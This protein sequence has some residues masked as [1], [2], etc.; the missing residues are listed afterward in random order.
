MQNVDRAFELQYMGAV[1]MNKALWP[2]TFGSFLKF[3][4]DPVFSETDIEKAK[5][6]AIDNVYARGPAPA[7]RIGAVPYGVL[8]VA[9][10]ARWQPR[11][12]EHDEADA[13]AVEAALLGPL[14][15]MASIWKSAASGVGRVKP[16]SQTPEVDS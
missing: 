5:R 16:Q 11:S 13:L 4:M 15:R 2:L 12:L 14:R 10:L 9:S 3:M 6:W 1:N 7:F 8:P